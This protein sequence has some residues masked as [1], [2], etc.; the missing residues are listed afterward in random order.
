MPME[1]AEKNSKCGTQT[2]QE[3]EIWEEMSVAML[4]QQNKLYIQKMKQERELEAK[5]KEQVMARQAHRIP[6]ANE[7]LAR[8]TLLRQMRQWQEA[9]LQGEGGA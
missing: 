1:W 8:W 9:Q 5:D 2:E 4:Y 7:A 3:L 6:I